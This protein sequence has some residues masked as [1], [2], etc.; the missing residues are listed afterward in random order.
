MPQALRALRSWFVPEWESEKQTKG[1]KVKREKRCLVLFMVIKCHQL[2]EASVL[3]HYLFFSFFW[4]PDWRTR[5]QVRWHLNVLLSC[6]LSSLLMAQATQACNSETGPLNWGP[7]LDSGIRASPRNSTTC[8]PTER[9]AAAYSWPGC[10][11]RVVFRSLN[12]DL[13]VI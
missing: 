2:N 7:H 5:R 6:D 9:S 12:C 8:S 10:S 1:R 11:E 13:S 3:S 4:W